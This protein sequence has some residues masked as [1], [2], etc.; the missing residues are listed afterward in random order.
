MALAGHRTHACQGCQVTPKSARLR[1]LLH[2]FRGHSGQ[3]Q[4]RFHGLCLVLEV[5]VTTTVIFKKG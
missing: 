4:N 3:P 2:C 1:R 5:G